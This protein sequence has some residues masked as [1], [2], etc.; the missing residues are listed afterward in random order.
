M[1]SDDDGEQEESTHQCYGDGGS[2]Q[3]E[4]AMLDML[5][6]MQCIRMLAYAMKASWSM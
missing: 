3:T 4:H 5:L 2:E 1:Q 6:T